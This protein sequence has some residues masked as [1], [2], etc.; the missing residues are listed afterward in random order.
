MLSSGRKEGD[1]TT[2]FGV[3]TW[4]L[5]TRAK[6]CS[7]SYLNVCVIKTFACFVSVQPVATDVGEWTSERVG[8]ALLSYLLFGVRHRPVNQ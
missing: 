5:I 6:F 7:Y 3:E 4:G 2:H 8:Q 1:A